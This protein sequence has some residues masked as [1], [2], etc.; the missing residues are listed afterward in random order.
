MQCS[1]KFLGLQDWW[2]DIKGCYDL[3]WLIFRDIL[4]LLKD[5]TNYYRS[6][7]EIHHIYANFAIAFVAITPC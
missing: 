3:L 7:H 2:Q 5:I 1:G 6:Y 4:F